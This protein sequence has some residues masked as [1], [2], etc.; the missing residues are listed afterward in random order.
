M[1]STPI[2]FSDIREAHAYITAAIEGSGVAT[3]SDYNLTKISDNVTAWVDGTLTLTV[4][5]DEVFWDAVADAQ[6]VSNDYGYH[7]IAEAML[8][9]ERDA[10]FELEDRDVPQDLLTALHDLA[11]STGAAIDEAYADAARAAGW[12]PIRVLSPTHPLL[13]EDG[14]TPEEEETFFL[15]ASQIDTGPLRDAIQ[16]VCRLARDVEWEMK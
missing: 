1:S 16:A 14:P 8:E 13:N 4:D 11:Y 10:I 3:A 12:N 15:A 2:T 7:G 6:L 5:D 9:E